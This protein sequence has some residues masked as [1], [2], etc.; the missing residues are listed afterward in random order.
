MPY[1]TEGLFF[2]LL[3]NTILMAFSNRV[4]ITGMIIFNQGLIIGCLMHHMNF[5]YN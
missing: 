3:L 1:I 4:Y 5:M 2:L